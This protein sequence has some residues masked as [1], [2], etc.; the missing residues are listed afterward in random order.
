MIF[1]ETLINR[2]VFALLRSISP[3]KLH[4]TVCSTQLRNGASNTG[5]Y[6]LKLQAARD[7][8]LVTTSTRNSRTIVFFVLFF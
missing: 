5:H 1:P 3:P 6:I 8:T 2:L 7:V 4:R